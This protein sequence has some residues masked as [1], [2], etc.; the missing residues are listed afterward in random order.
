MLKQMPVLS[1][2]LAFCQSAAVDGGCCQ[3]KCVVETRDQEHSNELEKLLR[4]N[5]TSVNFG[6]NVI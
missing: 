4:D 3:V 5:Y 6:P 2:L 1:L